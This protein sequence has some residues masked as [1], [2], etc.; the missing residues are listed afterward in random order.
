MFLL[1]WQKTEETTAW[2]GVV[3]V[4]VPKA[5]SAHLNT[6]DDGLMVIN[7]IRD[8]PADLAGLQQYDVILRLDNEAIG[9]GPAQ[10]GKLIQQ[11]QP[12]DLVTLELV[13]GATTRH[14]QV[15]LSERPTGEMEHVYEMPAD[16]WL[17]DRTDLRGMMLRKLPDGEWDMQHLGKLHELPGLDAKEL[18]EF[19][20]RPH[21]IQM[22][23]GDE[24]KDVEIKISVTDE[25]ETLTI[26]TIDGGTIKVTRSWEDDDGTHTETQEYADADALRL[27]DPEAAELYDSIGGSEPHTMKFNAWFGDEDP[28]LPDL[29]RDVVIRIEKAMKD[30]EEHMQGVEKHAEDVHRNV[31]RFGPHFRW[32]RDVHGNQGFKFQTGENGKII[33]DL[34]RGDITITFDDLADLEQSSKGLYEVYINRDTDKDE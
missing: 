13:R 9:E 28:D 17:S 27:A 20:I 11:R 22:E 7:V 29:D 18:H 2:L 21:V 25:G 15:Q 31:F 5:L 24:G 16:T 34:N 30:A 32:L 26:E 19:F 8:S 33:V 12:G 14:V 3:M 6:G 1:P 23:M 4:D 10:L